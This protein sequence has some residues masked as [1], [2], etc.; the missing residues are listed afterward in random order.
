MFLFKQMFKMR[1]EGNII[2]RGNEVKIQPFLSQAI[3]LGVNLIV[4]MDNG[5][6]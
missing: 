2:P 5:L 1:Q 4:H 3:I 6:F